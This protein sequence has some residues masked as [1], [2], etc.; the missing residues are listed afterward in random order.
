[1]D[2]NLRYQLSAMHQSDLRLE[3]GDR[4]RAAQVAR[5]HRARRW[6]GRF[7]LALGHTLIAQ[8][9]EQPSVSS[10][11]PRSGY[12]HSF[13][14]LSGSGPSCLAAHRPPCVPAHLPYGHPPVHPL[15]QGP[16]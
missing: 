10:R 5:A 2:P 16:G 3:A 13:L 9:G 1:M 14:A 15:Q 12:R 7:L 8:T 4:R 6:A 11:C